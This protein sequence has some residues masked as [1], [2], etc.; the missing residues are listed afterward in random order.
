MDKIYGLVNLHYDINLDSLTANRPLASV[1]FLGR[2]AFI[3]IPLSNMVNSGIEEIGILIKDKPR[4]LLKH[5]G[6]DRN[7]W[8]KNSKTGK[9]S[10]MYNEKHNNNPKYNH[11]VNN[12][13][14]NIWALEN[15][16][17]TYVVVAPAHIITRL[18]YRDVLAFHKAKKADITVV[19]AK[20]HSAKQ[21]YIDSDYYLFDEEDRLLDIKKNKGSKGSRNVGLDTLII[22]KEL[23]L[24]LIKQVAEISSF[25]SFLDLLNYYKKKLIISGYEHHGYVRFI[26]SLQQYLEVSF[27]MLNPEKLPQLFAA[28]WPIY[29]RTYDTPPTYYGQEAQV[30]DS[31][32]ANGSRILGH[33]TNS[34]IGRDVIIE[35]GAVVK[36]SILL[37]RVYVAADAKLNYVVA[38]KQAQIIKIKELQGKHDQCVVIKQE[39]IV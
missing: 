21:H 23:L 8:L 7:E 13:I 34:I 31:F 10:L 38:D 26:D 27:E 28:E 5:F 39:D 18:N 3:D 37:S 36:N 30:Q 14:E 33:V 6:L 25:F 32:V 22:S 29:T 20:V 12:L 15:T 9:M 24:D 19:Y 11:A 4:S 17:A 35:K 2:Y 16:N 1:G